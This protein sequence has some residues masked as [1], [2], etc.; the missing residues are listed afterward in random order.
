MKELK[1][2]LSPEFVNRI[3][4][5][6]VFNPLSEENIRNIVRMQFEDLKKRLLKNNSIK[7]SADKK[8][9]DHISKKS[10]DPNEG[11]RLVRR[12]LQEM[13]E[14]LISEKIIDGEVEGGDKVKL[15]IKSGKMMLA[16]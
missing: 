2:S 4:R 1:D 8:A 9:L 6:L 12:N 7:I 16:S 14:D 5:L 15:T 10:F 11:A 13:V 3:D